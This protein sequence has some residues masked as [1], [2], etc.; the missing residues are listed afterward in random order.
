MLDLIGAYENYLTNTDETG[1]KY[2]A[3]E[4]VLSHVCELSIIGSHFIALNASVVFEGPN[5]KKLL[6]EDSAFETGTGRMILTGSKAVIKNCDFVCGT[7]IYASAP[8][9][10]LDVYISNCRIKAS[11]YIFSRRNNNNGKFLFANNVIFGNLG[12]FYYSG[13]TSD[14]TGVTLLNNYMFNMSDAFK[15]GAENEIGNI[16]SLNNYVNGAS[17]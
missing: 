17:V 16:V 3:V 4:C 15:L 9:A 12:R 11:S 8:F 6:I 13:E 1:A 7:L 10:S 5:S 2:S 14:C